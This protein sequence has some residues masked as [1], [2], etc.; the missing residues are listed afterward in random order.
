MIMKESTKAIIDSVEE[1]SKSIYDEMYSEKN[2]AKAIRAEDGRAKLKHL[3]EYAIMSSPKLSDY[4]YN[5]I[6]IQ[7]NMK[8]EG[9][10][11]YEKV[12]TNKY[13]KFIRDAFK[14][15]GFIPSVFDEQVDDSDESVNKEIEK[16]IKGLDKVAT[17]ASRTL[18]FELAFGLNMEVEL[19]ETLL[20]KAMMQQGINAKDYKE[21]I[22][23][24]CLSN[25]FTDIKKPFG[26]CKKAKELVK[27]YNDDSKL[28]E[29]VESEGIKKK[30]DISDE[31]RT[32]LLLDELKG[33]EDE[34]DFYNY[35]YSLKI[36][37]IQR[38]KSVSR[39]QDFL[40]LLEDMPRA[41]EGYKNE[42]LRKF[43]KEVLSDSS[44]EEIDELVTLMGSENGKIIDLTPGVFE[45]TESMK[46]IKEK[47]VVLAYEDIE[48]IRHLV[49]KEEVAYS[50]HQL[51]EDEDD[52]VKFCLCEVLRFSHLNV[53]SMRVQG[54]YAVKE[55][56]ARNIAAHK[57]A[58]KEKVD[59]GMFE[60]ELL[61]KEVAESLFEGIVLTEKGI[62]NR[63]EIQ[64]T[65][66]VSR[67]EILFL[68][69]LVNTIGLLDD[70]KEQETYVDGLDENK[71]D[72]K[73]KK[74]KE[75]DKLG[76]RSYRNKSVDDFKD[77]ASEF[78]KKE[79]LQPIYLKSPFD[80]FLILCLMYEEPFEYIM[81]NYSLIS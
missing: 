28:K 3:V 9:N 63:S 45:S 81:A 18:V 16:V 7:S 58:A 15:N 65:V 75:L 5:Y 31:A 80:L 54:G 77:S 8:S 27:I 44:S 69:F 19:V 48:K 70:E 42:A 74:R 73:Q 62:R 36:A 2:V 66:S 64:T 67:K 29:I 55:R 78:L 56:A 59:K 53:N 13:N 33:I 72:Q 25:E 35:L 11:S 41:E 1:I 30:I 34:G 60:G 14:D 76:G 10:D 32:K 68:Y 37:N 61:E 52:F 17:T 50:G 39:T 57:V 51:I 12:T 23:W 22:Y 47:G 21:V 20:K 49:R 6:F 4:I 71:D 43:L 38:H 24:W 46:K 79:N 40:E 26:K